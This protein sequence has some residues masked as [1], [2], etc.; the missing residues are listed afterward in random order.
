MTSLDPDDCD[1]EF[2]YAEPD[3]EESWHYHRECPS[4]GGEWGALHC[5]HDGVQWPCSH[6]GWIIEGSRTPIELLEL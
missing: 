2:D 5:R 4:C 3:G 1:C 6:C